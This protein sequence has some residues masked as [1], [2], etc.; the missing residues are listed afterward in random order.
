[1]SNYAAV[2]LCMWHI[3]MKNAFRLHRV[4]TWWML[5]FS[6][7]HFEL[8]YLEKRQSCIYTWI[9][10]KSIQP[11]CPSF[12]SAFKCSMHN[13]VVL[14]SWR[15]SQTSVGEMCQ[16]TCAHS[17]SNLW[18]RILQMFLNIQGWEIYGGEVFVFTLC[19]WQP[20]GVHV[21]CLWI[22]THIYEYLLLRTHLKE[23]YLTC[24][25]DNLRQIFLHSLDTLHMFRFS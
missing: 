21:A 6:L 8:F 20:R 4:Y 5:A 15:E 16:V 18:I 12:P 10:S 14:R 17:F 7:K 25:W 19:T 1:M 24:I 11:R 9:Q 13:S 23:Y 3:K 22:R 2:P